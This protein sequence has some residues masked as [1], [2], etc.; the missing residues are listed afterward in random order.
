MNPA[1]RRP[2]AAGRTAAAVTGLTLAC[3]LAGCSHP[4]TD[5]VVL[6][7]QADGRPSAVEVRQGAQLQRLD[8]P[9]QAVE[10]RADALP[11]PVQL[12]A[13]AVQQ[14][15][16]GLIALQPM[17]PRLFVVQFQPNSNLLTDASQPA[18]AEVLA[19]L[20]QTPAPELVVIG[21]TDRVGSLEAN[22]RLSLVRAETVRDLLVA[23][24]VP[25]TA[26]SVVG[27]GERE[28]AVP[29]DDEVAEARNRRVEI[30]LR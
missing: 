5:R 27:R 19:A 3:L 22:D 10:A 1:L 30:K 9:Y 24:G 12:A 18:L 14:R 25:P 20:G 17:R 28:P 23:A 29:T 8:R 7:P 21:H 11:A 4:V 2:G 13:S 16:A 15:Y 26:V 6:L